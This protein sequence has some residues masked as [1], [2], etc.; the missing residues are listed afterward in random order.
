MYDEAELNYDSI[1]QAE[2]NYIAQTVF[3][4]R[5]DRANTTTFYLAAIGSFIAAILSADFNEHYIN[6]AFAFLFALLGLIGFRTLMELAQL[7]RAWFESVLAMNSIKQYYLNT[8]PDDEQFQLAFR[9]KF[10]QRPAGYK[11]FSI[12]SLLAYQTTLL[13]SGCF[14]ITTYFLIRHHAGET[15]HP[16]SY[17]LTWPAIVFVILFVLL[18]ILYIVLLSSE[19]ENNWKKAQTAWKRINKNNDGEARIS[20]S[21]DHGLEDRQAASHRNLVR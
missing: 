21:D 10:E 1:L 5:E 18:L 8:R 4:N 14:A 2:F 15:E 16:L 7:R 12:S 11:P 3:Q 13:A 9:W 17:W 20:I 6:L 19:P